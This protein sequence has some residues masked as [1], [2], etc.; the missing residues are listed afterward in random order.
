MRKTLTALAAAVLFSGLSVLSAPGAQAAGPVPGVPEKVCRTKTVQ[1][2]RTVYGGPLARPRLEA[3][4]VTIKD[5]YESCIRRQGLDSIRPIKTTVV[6]FQD[7][8]ENCKSFPGE[9]AYRKM[10]VKTVIK[11]A[12][13]S[14]NAA[15]INVKCVDGKFKTSSNS[16]TYSKKAQ[17][18]VPTKNGKPMNPTAQHSI[19]TDWSHAPDQNHALFIKMPL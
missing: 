7:Q 17:V 3:Y 11:G 12:Y 2:D 4:L 6:V 19:I 16:Y 15:Q 14:V 8:D 1:D 5:K 9:V 10:V 13:G 18:A